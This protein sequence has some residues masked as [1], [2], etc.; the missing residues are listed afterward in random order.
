MFKYFLCNIIL[1]MAGIE[2][3]GK[4]PFDQR[5]YGAALLKPTF[6]GDHYK[7][8]L[9]LPVTEKSEER[10][11]SRNVFTEADLKE[12]K[13]LFRDDLGGATYFELNGP[14]PIQGDWIDKKGKV[15]VDW[16]IRIEL[17]TKKHERAL[18]YF[19]ELKARL[20][21][22]AREVRQ[23]EQEDIVIER[24]T[25]NFV[26]QIPLKALITKPIEKLKDLKR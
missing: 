6:E 16:H 8:T 11:V 5:E 12:L 25:V 19:E 9:L 23:M 22:H 14:P 17:Y 3:I 4:R 13:R 2:K 20:L 7:F 1:L 26:P 24:A 15:V 21:Q 10:K 18:G